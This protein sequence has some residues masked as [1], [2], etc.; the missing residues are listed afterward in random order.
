MILFITTFFAVV[1]VTLSLLVYTLNR[2][3]ERL[4]EIDAKMREIVNDVEALGDRVDF[5]T[6]LILPPSSEIDASD[7]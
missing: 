5:L 4:D 1:L 3:I 6:P 2:S 7:R